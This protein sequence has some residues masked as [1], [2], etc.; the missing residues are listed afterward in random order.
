[1]PGFPDYLG[2]LILDWRYKSLRATLRNQ[3]VGRQYMELQ[4][5]KDF[6]IDPYYTASLSV[7]YTL[8]NIPGAGSIKLTGRVDNLFDAKY[9]VSGYG[10]NYAYLDGGQVVVGGWAEYY[11]AAERSFYGEVK[12]ELY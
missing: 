5:I 3:F 4:N 12:V 10:G 2:N 6:S 9:E 8:G 1:V 7:S 11:P